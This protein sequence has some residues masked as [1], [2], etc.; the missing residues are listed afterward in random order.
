MRKKMKIFLSALAVVMALSV[1]GLAD[2]IHTDYDKKAD[3]S[4]YHTYTWH[5]VKATNSLWEQ[6]ITDAVDKDLQA[7]GWQKVDSDGDVAIT[8]IGAT[9]DKQEYQTF[10]NG[11]EPGWGWWGWRGPRNETTEVINYRTGTLVLDMYD[12]N[13]KRLI[14]RGTASDTVDKK[15]EKNEKKLE[16]AVDKMLDKFPPKGKE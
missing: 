16:K 3:F 14:W 13:S 5:K 2:D 6:R 11:F 7:K 15:P 8:A 4:H 10:Y 1:I 12:T 9:Q